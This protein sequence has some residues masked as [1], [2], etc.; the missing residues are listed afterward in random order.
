M[1]EILETRI[2][3]AVLGKVVCTDNF[4]QDDGLRN[5]PF[6]QENLHTRM[7]IEQRKSTLTHLFHVILRTY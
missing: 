7:H 2:N 1:D 3:I 5:W 6:E 4:I